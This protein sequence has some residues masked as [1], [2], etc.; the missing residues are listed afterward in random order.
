AADSARFFVGYSGWGPGQLEAELD[1][2]AWLTMAATGQIVFG[3]D[4][5]WQRLVRQIGGTQ[6]IATLGI[7]HVPPDPRMN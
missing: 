5:P 2:G 3:S 6:L 1:G 7:K 4:D